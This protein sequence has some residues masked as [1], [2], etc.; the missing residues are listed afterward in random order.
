M[1]FQT[2]HLD[3]AIIFPF[4]RNPFK[5]WQKLQFKV[6]LVDCLVRPVFTI[7]RNSFI[8]LTRKLFLLSAVS[9]KEII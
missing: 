1:Q 7:T 5:L 4:E 6:T 9:F 8:A 2:T 3:D